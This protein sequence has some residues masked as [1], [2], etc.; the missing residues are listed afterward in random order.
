MKIKNILLIFATIVLMVTPKSEIALS[1]DSI[2]G[3]RFPELSP[4]GSSLIFSYQGDLWLANP[5][6][7]IAS[8]ITSHEAYEGRSRF[9]SDGKLLAFESNRFG[10]SDIFVMPSTGSNSPRRITYS[11]ANQSIG[12]W[13]PDGTNILIIA[14]GSPF[15]YNLK[16]QDLNGGTSIPLFEDFA[17]HDSPI[18]TSDGKTVYY[19]RGVG[20]VDWWR[21]GYRGS[22]DYDIWA[23]NLDTHEHKCI[24]SDNRS[25]QFLRLSG[26]EK[27]LY[28]V[29]FID[30]GSSNIAKL[31]IENGKITY[32]TDYKD[33]TVRNITI[34]KN[35]NIIY[36]YMN[37]LWRLEPGKKPELLA[38]QVSAEDK[39]NTKEFQTFSGNIETANISDDGKLLAIN[40][41]GD[42]FAYRTDGEVD[43]KGVTLT[44]TSGA[45]DSESVFSKDA[46]SI[47][48]L[49]D[50]GNGNHLMKM[51]LKTRAIEDL[52]FEPEGMRYLLKVPTTELLSYMKGSGDIMIFDTE[53]KTSKKLISKM[54]YSCGYSTTMNWSPDGHYLALVDQSQW[55][56]EIF[57]VDRET[58]EAHNVSHSPAWDDDPYFSPDGKWFTYSQNQEGQSSVIL[59]ELDPKA[60]VEETQLISEEEEKKEGEEKTS[61]EKKEA[62]SEEK[63]SE[64]EKPA[65]E[66]EKKEEEEKKIEVKIVFDRIDE[67]G[68]AVHVTPGWNYPVG[69]SIDGKWI[70]YIHSIKWEQRELW[71]VPTDEKSKEQPKNLGPIGGQWKFL[72]SKDSMF[73]LADA[74]IFKFDPAS[75]RGEELPF[76]VKRDLDKDAERKLAFLVAVK[77]LE[78]G[79]YD[80]KMH[81]ADWKRV[82]EKYLPMI[83]DARTPED[84]QAILNRVNG[85]LN[86]SH[87]YAYGPS[88]YTGQ[89]DETASLGLEW[90]YSFDGPGLKI[91]RI[92]KN[93]PADFPDIELKQGDIVLKIDGHDVD[94]KHDP[95]ALLNHKNDE[96]VKLTVKGEKENREVKIRTKDPGADSNGRYLT[97]IEENRKLVDKLSDG[98]LGYLH[99]QWMG[100][101]SLA[102]FKKEY[103]NMTREKKGV[104]IDVRF[105]PGG[106]IHEELLDI[107]DKSMFGYGTVR[108][109]DELI[110]QP[111]SYNRTPSICLI[112]ESSY[113]DSEIFPY[114]YQQ[115]KLGKLVG[116]Q[117]FGAVIGTND[118]GIPGGYA[119][120][121]PCEGWYRVDLRNLE[122]D[123]VKPDI[124][125]PWPPDAISKGKDPQIE[126]AVEELLKEI[127]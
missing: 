17:E 94:I 8:R 80:A 13:Y 127:K 63:K 106:N 108:G 74:K 88:S 121:I 109:W 15:A 53:K 68:R 21:T 22:A 6:G 87:L 104:I 58:G 64:E 117:T 35:N 47:Y 45:T 93:A 37:D 30:Q 82:K 90:D 52:I 120:R 96:I 50:D 66:G 28:F 105:N 100:G 59:V 10:N 99:I 98:R 24:Y 119:I 57:I 3:I 78:Q 85:E 124:E 113:S 75:G 123:G 70:F 4:D 114:A 111:S 33:D 118:I 92:Y 36:E 49:T 107:L 112:N 44:E 34:D 23:Y 86:A 73:V 2:H 14:V 5:N 43:N 56:G 69:F 20:G 32:L 42:I 51:D 95:S 97:W 39:N 126:R 7:G 81:G 12:A 79:F 115:L 101:R 61:D 110:P 62:V 1:A 54:C 19:L 25:Q 31:N 40:I 103:M 71:A 18:I 102:K 48:Y 46:K 77:A 89:K 116:M 55:D 122:N 27:S 83:G 38:F 16:R 91:N 11:S 26:D 76:I 41:G 67:R 9:S 84:T 72:Y 29:D 65:K 125:V 60:P